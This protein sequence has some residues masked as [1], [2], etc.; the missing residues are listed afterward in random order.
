MALSDDICQLGQRSVAALDETMEYFTHSKAAWKLLLASIDQGAKFTVVTKG[1]GSQVNQE[2]LKRRAKRYIKERLT[3]AAFQESVTYFESF[4][5][6]FLAFWVTEYPECLSAKQL[7]FRRVLEAADRAEIIRSVV[8]HQLNELR[9]EAVPRWF[10]DLERRTKLGVPSRDR[11]ESLTEIKATRD[12]LA[13]GLGTANETYVRKAGRLARARAGE[14]LGVP[15]AY[16]C[17][18]WQ[19]I[20]AVVVE[21]TTAADA[22]LSP[23]GP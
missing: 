5:F 4:L 15:T 21:L 22:K 18:S 11:I 8:A 2:E 17:A 3:P 1:V 20:R 13:H 10:D 12:I 9:Y 7:D 6:D 16:F 19:T 14:P 23:A